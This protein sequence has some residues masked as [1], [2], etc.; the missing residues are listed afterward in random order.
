MPDITKTTTPFQKI[1]DFII[2]ADQLKGVIR[3][4]ALNNGS[5]RENT[6][7][8]AWHVALSALLLAPYANTP[9][10]ACKV[11]QMLLIHDLI[12]IE[13]GDTFVYDQEAVAAQAEQEEKAAQYIFAK[14]PSEQGAALQSL[15]E[16]FEA[17][18]TPE[19]KF[20]KAMDRFL[21]LLSNAQNGGFSWTPDGISQQQVRMICS[22]IEEG[23]EQLWLTTEDIINQAVRQGILKS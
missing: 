15:W 16:E 10:D 1:I 8:H 5:R 13:A 21:P 12:E 23:S 17:R 2:Y 19:A 18:Q 6:A 11:I 20:A 9:I 4:N 3:R 22:I 7:E 14:L